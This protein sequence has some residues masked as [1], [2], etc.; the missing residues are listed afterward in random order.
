M[1]N[2]ASLGPFDQNQAALAEWHDVEGIG[3][4]EEEILEQLATV[5]VYA[6]S[7][8]LW[9]NREGFGLALSILITVLEAAFQ[10]GRNVGAREAME[11]DDAN[12]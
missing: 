3:K 9:K 5:G 12:E 7:N 8:A 4:D 1:G 2:V 6:V 10:L 11:A